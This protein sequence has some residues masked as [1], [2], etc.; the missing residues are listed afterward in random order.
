MTDASDRVPRNDTQ[1]GQTP[2]GVSGRRPRFFWQVYLALLGVIVVFFALSLALFVRGNPP[3]ARHLR[4]AIALAEVALP[5]SESGAIAQRRIDAFARA[6]G[7]SAAL[8]S[9]DGE[10]IAEAGARLPRPRAGARE[11][12]FT[13]HPFTGV[14]RLSDGRWLV[15]AGR[16]VEPPHARMLIGLIALALLVAAG[17]WPVARGVTRRLELLTTRVRAFGGGDLGA[18]AD[19][20]GRDE[21]AALA[22]AFNESAERI[23][24]LVGG[25]RALLASAS[26]ELRSPLA[27]MR[28]AAELLAGAGT[29][30]SVARREELREQLARDIGQIDAAVDELLAV[31]RLDLLANAEHA[32]VDAL[33]LAAEEAAR[34]GVEAS[35][36]PA[37]L[38][39]DA[40][41]LRHLLRNLIANA[42]RHAAGAELFVSAEPLDPARPERGARFVVEDAGPGV[43]EAERARIFE[44]FARG[45]S[46]STEGAGLGLAIA[47]QIARHHGGEL[48]Y[49]PRPGGGSRF[50]A[51]LPGR[52]R[53]PAV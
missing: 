4:A 45:A 48:R 47:R 5:A 16:E 49:E 46:A 12:Y 8:Y 27:R 22:R 3:H 51:E 30:L 20:S 40:R 42:Q 34:A 14:A 53:A 17:A 1:R 23:E 18:R 33:A 24:R 2:I 41:S 32:P 21:I 35:G 15:I 7:G 28:I 37:Q 36:A 11:T 31:S 9:A 10:R 44:P 39:G 26:H 6:L 38:V 50:V 13:R 19:A 52:T 25:Q 29:E 43:P